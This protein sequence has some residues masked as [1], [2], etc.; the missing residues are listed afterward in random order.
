MSA[1]H[2]LIY[3]PLLVVVPEFAFEQLGVYGSF[4]VPKT[5]PVKPHVGIA[6]VPPLSF[7][8]IALC[9]LSRRGSH[10]PYKKTGKACYIGLQRPCNLLFVSDDG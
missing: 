7:L 6:Y 9:E 4:G 3:L 8:H 10:V 1:N 5:P 2:N